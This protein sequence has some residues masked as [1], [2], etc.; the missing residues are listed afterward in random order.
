MFN[1]EGRK[2]VKFFF[3]GLSPGGADEL[4]SSNRTYY[5]M[6]IEEQVHDL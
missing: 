6:K 4:E 3:F 5:V 1:R 2:L